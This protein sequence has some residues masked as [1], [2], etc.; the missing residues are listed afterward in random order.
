MVQ[1]HMVKP[2]LVSA[3]NEKLVIEFVYKD[4]QARAVEPHDYGIRDGIAKMLAYQI[5][6]A[7]RSGN[8]RGWKWYEVDDMRR[9]TL[10]EQHFPG[11]RADGTQQHFEW[12]VLF[13]RVK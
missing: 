2:R 7:S 1:M 8:P 13:A 10:L 3:I 6:G 5:S 11:S 12:D 4:G 9:L